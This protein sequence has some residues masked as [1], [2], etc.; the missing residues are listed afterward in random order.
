[1][2][3]Y[4]RLAAVGLTFADTEVTQYVHDDDPS[5]RTFPIVRGDSYNNMVFAYPG[6][7]GAL[8]TYSKAR[9]EVHYEVIRLREAIGV[10]KYKN[11]GDTESRIFFPPAALKVFNA[12]T[13]DLET[14]FVVEGQMKALAMSHYGAVAVGIGGIWNFKEGKGLKGDL[15][16]YIR[17][18][19][20]RRVCLLF[21]A[22]AR[23][24]KHEKV[25]AGADLAERLRSFHGAVVTFR[26]AAQAVRTLDWNGPEIYY[27]QVAPGSDHK[28]VDDLLAVLPG[29]DDRKKLMRALS[30]LDPA[31]KQFVIKNLSGSSL[32]DLKRYFLLQS[33]KAFYEEYEDVISDREFIWQGGKY[34]CDENG[35]V[36]EQRHAH[37]AAYIRVASN[38]YKVIYIE[39]AYGI[40]S[41]NIKPWQKSEIKADY[42][43]KFLKQIE[44]YDD[45]CNSPHLPGDIYRHETL[46]ERDGQRF[47][48][49]NRYS[50]LP[51]TPH[52]GQWPTIEMFLR[53]IFKDHYE[54]GLDWIQILY[55]NPAHKL[56]IICLVSEQKATGKSKLI[57][58]MCTIFGANA[59]IV[60]NEDFESGFNSHYT[61]KLVVGIEEGLIE[62]QQVMEKI[63]AMNT[64]NSIGS[65]SK[66][67]D[68]VNIVNLMHF[69]LTSNN[70]DNFLR[71]DDKENR[72]WVIQ[73]NRFEG[74]EIPDKEMLALFADE[75][76]AFLHFLM[77]RK[78][79]Y[80][81]S[82]TRFW[83][84]YESYR[85]DALSNVVTNSRSSL[86]KALDITFERLA[87]E[88]G[89]TLFYTTVTELL[90]EL[91]KDGAEKIRQGWLL[92]TLKK[93]FGHNPISRQLIPNSYMKSEGGKMKPMDFVEKV[94]R[95]FEI[96]LAKWYSPEEFALL[97]DVAVVKELELAGEETIPL[98]ATPVPEVFEEVDAE[99]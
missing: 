67:K 59:T 80:P 8:Q 62:K 64:N 52:A 30:A 20:P 65:M 83:F 63:K 32:L 14:L 99:F 78:M 71:I 43:E 54:M 60:G 53:H 84:P 28:G 75:A 85:T 2:Y 74:E 47:R 73:V 19:K 10:N 40:I 48:F 49:Y 39:D 57:D 56:P 35:V 61:D 76:P 69:I 70:V 37:A 93:K 87:M 55:T 17:K 1:M 79:L 18:V 81:V 29:I 6:L 38:Y 92:N 33:V 58:L 68:K 91:P 27:A 5:P 16:E 23:Q 95:W 50:P 88:R 98:L 9:K 51:H 24:V 26:E 3:A 90:T 11:P 42:G 46:T 82:K 12:E 72:F 25:E 7:D 22:D 44:L 13:P 4:S 31:V 45:F 94:G 34:K 41:R 36:K 97:Q 66:G 96:D 15:A 77:D 86:E 21:D 89:Q